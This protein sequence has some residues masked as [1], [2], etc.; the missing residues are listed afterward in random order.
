MF[1]VVSVLPPSTPRADVFVFVTGVRSN[2]G[3]P[4]SA[5]MLMFKLF[6]LQAYCALIIPT[7]FVPTPAPTHHH[8]HHHTHPTTTPSPIL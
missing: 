6:T 4:S 8:T 2:A 3:I 1:P 5:Y 7:R